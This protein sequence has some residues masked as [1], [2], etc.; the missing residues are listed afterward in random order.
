M[1]KTRIPLGTYA[2]FSRYW[3]YLHHRRTRRANH[4]AKEILIG[5]SISVLGAVLA[6]Y[7]LELNKTELAT[8]AGAFLILPGVFDL[9]G[10]IAG[11]MAARLNHRLPEST[12]DRTVIRDALF[13]AM[14]LTCA[15]SIILGLFGATLGA[16]FFDAGFL[17]LLVVT[18]VSSISAGLVGFPLVAGAT[19]LAYKRGVDPDN[20]IGPIETSVFDTLTVLMVTLMVVI[21]R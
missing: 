21:L 15:A 12:P 17:K 9:G 5:Q 19:W 2:H 6:G 16:L 13:H 10:S 14:L 7:V 18:I 11:A 4:T 20:F 8:M 1:S 3:H